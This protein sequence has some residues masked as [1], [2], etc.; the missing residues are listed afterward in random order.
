MPEFS[1]TEEQS[2]LRDLAR[3]FAKTE[4]MPKVVECDRTARFPDEV[5]RKAYDL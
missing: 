5:Y 1:L 4:M 2:S 3:K